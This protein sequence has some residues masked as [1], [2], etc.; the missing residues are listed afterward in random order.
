MFRKMRGRHI[1]SMR[2]T[3]EGGLYGYC[4]MNTPLISGIG[5]YRCLHV[6]LDPGLR[7][8]PQKFP[9]FSDRGSELVLRLAWN[10]LTK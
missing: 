9:W 3:A 5:I 7:S 6:D 2:P 4:E 10:A 8:R 1:H